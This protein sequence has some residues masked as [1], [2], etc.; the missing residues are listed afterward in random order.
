MWEPLRRGARNVLRRTAG[1]ELSAVHDEL[2]RRR[3]KQNRDVDLSSCFNSF[4]DGEP[5]SLRLE[6]L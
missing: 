1:C 5:L 3:F 4:P 6:T 2:K